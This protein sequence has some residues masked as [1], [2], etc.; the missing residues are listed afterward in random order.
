MYSQQSSPSTADI[1]ETFSMQNFDIDSFD[2][3]AAF[4]RPLDMQGGAFMS[5]AFDTLAK[6]ASHFGTL[7]TSKPQLAGQDLDFS[8]FMSSLQYTA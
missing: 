6:D 1:D 4:D 2:H 7:G 8:S 3:T 5:P